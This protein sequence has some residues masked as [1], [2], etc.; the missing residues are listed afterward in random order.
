MRTPEIK[1]LIHQ[2]LSTMHIFGGFVL[3]DT[4]SRIG[5]FDIDADQVIEM[6]HNHCMDITGT[7]GNE[8]T[9]RVWLQPVFCDNQDRVCKEWYQSIIKNISFTE[10]FRLSV[11]VLEN[12][13]EITCSL[14]RK[15]ADY[16]QTIGYFGVF[17]DEA[18]Y[19]QSLCM[20]DAFHL[21]DTVGQT[22]LMNSPYIVPLQ[23]AAMRMQG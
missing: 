14:V 8:F 12:L 6:V 11:S 7:F 22:V 18:E 23:N 21:R 16:K 17:A 20:P 19:L 5:V 13:K 10:S 3:T 1:N 9:G 2:S 4:A 15:L